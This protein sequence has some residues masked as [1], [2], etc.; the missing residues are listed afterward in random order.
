VVYCKK[1]LRIFIIKYR[2]FS[3]VIFFTSPIHILSIWWT[4]KFILLQQRFP[5][6]M[7][8]HPRQFQRRSQS[9]K[10]SCFYCTNATNTKYKSDANQ[11][12]KKTLFKI[13]II[14]ELIK[15]ARTKSKTVKNK[16]LINAWNRIRYKSFFDIQKNI[17]FINSLN[18]G[19]ML[20]KYDWS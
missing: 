16:I 10:L 13:S 9:L 18:A 8:Q 5:T 12:G 20:A 17:I 19:I 7:A 6:G 3:K 4:S 14:S 2:T 1:A 15:R 11:Y